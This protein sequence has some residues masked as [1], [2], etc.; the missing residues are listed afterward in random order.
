MTIGEMYKRSGGAYLYQSEQDK[1]FHPRGCGE[2]RF[3]KEA[4]MLYKT[5]NGETVM[6]GECTRSRSDNAWKSS[7]IACKYFKE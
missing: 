6:R 5:V 7:F 1:L 3:F 2:C 4:A